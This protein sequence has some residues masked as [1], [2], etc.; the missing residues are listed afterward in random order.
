[1]TTNETDFEGVSAHKVGRLQPTAWAFGVLTVLAAA[2]TAALFLSYVPNESDRV[3]EA[4]TSSF[5]VEGV[6]QS[7]ALN[8]S[9]V[10]TSIENHSPRA[11]RI[12][13]ASSWLKGIADGVILPNDVTLRL[14]Q[15]HP[16]VA[17]IV[18]EAWSASARSTKAS[19]T[20]EPSINRIPPQRSL[21]VGRDGS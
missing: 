19:V 2:I 20:R 14:Q 9:V 8:E 10:S 6:E 11:R 4:T 1:M 16:R 15:R 5:S 7:R 21:S 18:I 17:K 13:T 12:E 3:G